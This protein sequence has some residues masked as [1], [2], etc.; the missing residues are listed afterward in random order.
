MK[1]K[2]D[3]GKLEIGESSPVMII[4]ELSANH[5]QDLNLAIKTIKAAKEAGADAI[6]I[7]TYTA[8]T[9]TI[10]SDTE[11]FQIKGGLWDGYTLHQLYQE[12]YTPWEWHK[13]LQSVASDLRLEFFSSPFDLTAVDFLAELDV[14]AYK[15]ASYEIQDI[16]LIEYA[17]K[18]GKPMIIS[19]GIADFSDI[20]LAVQT[21]KKAGNEQIILLHCI[22]QYPAPMEEMNLLTIQDLADK[23]G[24]IVGLSDHTMESIAAIASVALGAKVVEKHLILDRKMGGPDSGFS[25]EP[26]EFAKMVEQIRNT[27]KSLGKP[28]YELSEKKIESR[29]HGR[30]LFVVKSIKRGEKI[31]HKNVRSIRPSDGMHPKYLNEIIGKKAKEDIPFATPLSEE[32]ISD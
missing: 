17:A 27:E 1:N 10:D 7:Q 21:C 24:V 31:T 28:T 20:E 16:P 13:E 11:L 22:S 4:A 6:K 9:I 30:S 8:D 25:I 26:H 3:F 5:N 18:Q 29:K 23:F 12:A 2:V 15:I 14:P 32:L 19:T